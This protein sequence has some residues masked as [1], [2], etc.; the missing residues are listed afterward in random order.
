MVKFTVFGDGII[1]DLSSRLALARTWNALSHDASVLLLMTAH[2]KQ[3]LSEKMT[4]T[5]GMLRG[6]DG[7][8]ARVVT[9]LC[10]G[11]QDCSQSI[12][13]RFLPAEVVAEYRKFVL[14]GCAVGAY[15]ATTGE[16]D[17]PWEHEPIRLLL[18]DRSSSAEAQAQAR[19]M[20]L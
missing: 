19:K 3:R 20:E 18:L 9:A 12:T 10:R 5:L 6:R 8:L 1:P 17:A 14:A 4:S 15:N 2:R 16:E 7:S 13:P 11:R